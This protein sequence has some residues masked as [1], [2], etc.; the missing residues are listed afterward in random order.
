MNDPIESAKI[1]YVLGHTDGYKQ[2]MRDAEPKWIPCSER[3]PEA[4]GIY[5]VTVDK[6]CLG[7]DENSVFHAYWIKGDWH[8]DFFEKRKYTRILRYIV[9][10]IDDIKIIAWMPLPEPYKEGVSE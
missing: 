9:G 2:G 3:V 8:H 10:R 4:E 5:L 7:E 6:E 1:N